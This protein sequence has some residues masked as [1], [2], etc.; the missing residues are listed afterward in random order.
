M[1]ILQRL[2]AALTRYADAQYRPRQA[3]R[4][5]TPEAFLGWLASQQLPVPMLRQTI[6]GT[7]D[8][9]D[10][11]FAGFAQSGY[12]GN[13]IIF[14]CMQA[15]LMLFSE[16]RFQ[17]RRIRSGRPGELFGTA[18]LAR[19]EQPWP[20]GTT[21][22]LLSRVLVSADL[23]GNAFIAANRSGGLRV[24]R[25][26]WVTMILG[27]DRAPVERAE[28]VEAELIAI[29]YQ[30]GGRAGGAA[31]EVF[32]RGEFG[33][34]A[35]IPD[36]FAP[37]RGMSWMTPL[38]REIRGD[39]GYTDH[40]LKFLEQ[41]A[42]VNLVVTLDKDIGATAFTHW[43]DEMEKGHKGVANAYKTLYLGGGATPTAIG[44]DMVQMDFKAVQGAGE[45]RI[46][47]AAGVPPVVVGFSEGLQGSSLNAGNYSAARRR[48]ADLTM[49]PLWRNVAGSLSPLVPVPAGAELWY[50]DRDISFLQ[51]DVRDA[52][53]I[54]FVKA[55]TIR[56]LVD[57][58][59]EPG[60]VIAAVVAGDMNRLSHTGM[61]SVQLNAA[62]GQTEPSVID[63]FNAG[64]MTETE[65]RAAFGRGPIDWGDT[66][67]ESESNQ[68]IELVKAGLLTEAEAREKMGRQ[69]I[70]WGSDLTS[71]EVASLIEQVKAGLRTE[72]E[73]RGLMKL[74]P[75]E[76]SNAL[77]AEESATMLEQV[78]AGLLTEAEAR[79]MMGRKPIDWGDA[80]STEEVASLIEQVK[81]GLLSVDEAR[82][83]LG[84]PA[85]QWPE[86]LSEKVTHL[87]ELI[88]AG[89][90]PA[91]ALR[92]LGL[93]PIKHI[94][95]PPVTVQKPAD[96]AG[97]VAQP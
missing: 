78:K 32:L 90:D 67:S 97:V 43:V 71:E 15:R 87:G 74:P 16:A 19:L 41:G 83:M 69:P 54:E 75:I 23:S 45:T 96:A 95:L 6:Q 20:G 60:S 80:V 85:M 53:D 35:P 61:L 18:G 88:K 86:D 58:G 30:P 63:Q 72:N 4:F 64:L 11:T 70:E 55:Q 31:P 81:E 9:V 1:G 25:P 94:G 40:K 12:G 73:A 82:Q 39:T 13:A 93:D 68:L 57:G 34:F 38:V 21:G 10:P 14:A 77:S 8:T 49:R 56:Q 22:D 7:T 48:F 50:D 27:S 17:Y 29:A 42:T 37:F 44:S 62:G 33:H 76:W 66:L 36:P 46:A 3:E 89:F 52:A 65:A 5:A 47:A 92:T 24:L 28:D 84:R 79:E 91:D 26:D 51:E 2:D 59:F